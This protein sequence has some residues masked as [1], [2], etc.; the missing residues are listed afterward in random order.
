MLYDFLPL[1]V[2]TVGVSTSSN[3]TDVPIT[4]DFAEENGMMK[5]QKNR[6]K[7][8]DLAAGKDSIMIV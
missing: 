7:D 6:I 4:S 1:T 5:E 3:Q 8:D 2:W